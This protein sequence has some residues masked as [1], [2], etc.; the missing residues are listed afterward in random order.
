MHISIGRNGKDKRLPE[1]EACVKALR[2]EHGFKKIGAAGFCYGGWA[3][4]QLGAKGKDLVDCITMAH[5]S[6]VTKEEIDKCGVPVQ[7]NAPET[8][9]AFTPELKAYANSTMPTLNIP[10]DYQYYPGANHGFAI[11]CDETKPQA[12]ADL[13]RNK[14]A[15]AY[16]FHQFLKV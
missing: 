1:M 15:M 8:D 3:C 11:K 12:K 16:W 14:N 10:Y 4:F 13:E 9:G 7:I 2:N 6:I 5:P